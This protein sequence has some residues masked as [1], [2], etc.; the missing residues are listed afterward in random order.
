VLLAV[1]L[2]EALH[3][4]LV[5]DVEF[6]LVL[7]LLDDDAPARGK[8]RFQVRVRLQ[9]L[10]LDAPDHQTQN[11]LRLPR[12]LGRLLR[13]AGIMKMGVAGALADVLTDNLD[14]KKSEIRCYTGDKHRRHLENRD[15]RRKQSHIPKKTGCPFYMMSQHFISIRF[16]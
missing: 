10:T 13:L 15:C 2:A 12:A 8:Q 1:A 5:H 14:S 4:G 16:D 7:A 9:T 11:G 6:V 3:R